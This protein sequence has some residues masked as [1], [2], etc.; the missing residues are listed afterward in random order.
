MRLDVEAFVRGVVQEVP[1]RA[2]RQAFRAYKN[3]SC[4]H[5]ESLPTDGRAQPL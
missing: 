3:A 4:T 5:Q 1:L 2:V